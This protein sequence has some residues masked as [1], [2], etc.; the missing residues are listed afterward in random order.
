MRAASPRVTSAAPPN[1]RRLFTCFRVWARYQFRLTTWSSLPSSSSP[2][3][4]T[5]IVCFTLSDRPE[6]TF[7]SRRG[8]RCHT[9]L[10]NHRG[11]FLC[12][13]LLPPTPTLRPRPLHIHTTRRYIVAPA[14][15]IFSH[16]YTTEIYKEA[17]SFSSRRP[18]RCHPNASSRRRQQT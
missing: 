1:K 3:T 10:H 11:A 7:G 14:T 18:P 16:P 13:C 4:G 2:Q 6:V 17:P 8:C 12:L 5:V 9:S 15:R